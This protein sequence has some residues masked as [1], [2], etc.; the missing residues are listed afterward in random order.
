MI[1][2]QLIIK[3]NN[4]FY[5]NSKES[6]NRKGLKRVSTVHIILKSRIIVVHSSLGLVLDVTEGY[7]NLP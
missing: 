7:R 1:F 5:L 6:E 4:L 2:I 3:Y